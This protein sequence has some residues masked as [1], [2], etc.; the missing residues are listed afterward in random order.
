[1]ERLN[2]KVVDPTPRVK[3]A[4][5][6]ICPHCNET[7]MENQG[8]TSRNENLVKVWCAYC[9]KEYYY[10]VNDNILGALGKMEFVKDRDRIEE[11]SALDIDEIKEDITIIYFDIGCFLELYEDRISICIERSEYQFGRDELGKA[12]LCLIQEWC[13][14]ELL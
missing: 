10:I 12:I 8:S 14:D 11:I 1:M 5:A 6:H 13:L 4:N 3:D 9:G 7:H 2:G